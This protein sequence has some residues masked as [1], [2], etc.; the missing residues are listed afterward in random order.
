MAYK[1]GSSKVPIGEMFHPAPTARSGWRLA[2]EVSEQDALQSISSGQETR[3]EEIVRIPWNVQL[4]RHPI[5]NST[6]AGMGIK[7]PP[8]PDRAGSGV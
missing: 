2:G 8:G 7:K 1:G 5:S 4:E 6:I 3:C